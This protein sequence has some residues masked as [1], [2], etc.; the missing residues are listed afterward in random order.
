MTSSSEETKAASVV[1]T[2][3]PVGVQDGAPVTD[4][5]EEQ[6]V[7]ESFSRRETRRGSYTNGRRGYDTVP[8]K[9]VY[10]EE[11]ELPVWLAQEKEAEQ[12][13]KYD[14]YGSRPSA[15]AAS[16]Q[17]GE[18]TLEHN[19]RYARY[20]TG[21]SGSSGTETSVTG[22]NNDIRDAR[23][24][25]E[26][27]A[28]DYRSNK[29]SKYEGGSR[30]YDNN[31]RVGYGNEG[32]VAS[33]SN[34]PITLGASE[35]Q[36]FHSNIRDRDNKDINDIVRD[37]YNQRTKVSKFQ[38]SRVQSPIYKMRNFNN[39]IKYML[40]GN[41]A[42]SLPDSGK[43]K[44]MLDLCCGK[45]GDLNKC[46]F[47]GVDHYIGVDISDGS[48]K[49][50]YSR[51]S[52]N[53]AHFKL[54][55]RVPDSRKYTFEACFATGDCFSTPIPDILE[56]HFPGIIENLFPVDC[57]S[58]QFSLHYSF[59]T[60]EK[61]RTLITNVSKSLRPG[62]V[63]VGTIPSSDFIKEKIIRKDFL[64]PKKFGNDL[65]Q[66]TFERDPP[67][68]GVFRPPFG[69]KY[70]YFLQDAVDNIPEYVVPFETLRSLCED[71]GLTLKYRKSF[72]EMFNLEI[73]KYFS[74]L[75]RHLIDGM[76]RTDGKY[77][78]EGLEKEAVN[79]YLAFAFEKLD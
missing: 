4:A 38:G 70:N 10:A 43:P 13:N 62:G 55:H 41:F 24:L 53:K 2:P 20:R 39:A 44:V 74:Q 57:V 58:V 25:R 72:I 1:A 6:D 71:A 26:A 34:L 37:H 79:F 16:T 56:P 9:S 19:D 30:G 60:E 29:R 51:Y 5:R 21:G 76:R 78:V 73:P 77:G 49:E 40:L 3:S 54:A 15:P 36:T 32:N 64:S 46:E 69:N 66:V 14:K 59:E 17:R 67:E 18:R 48:V 63:F 42:R 33:Y 50:A 28:N 35:Y 12:R 7:S 8:S 68:D 11:K 31:S 65:Y 27:T 47:I 75:N 61:A 52:K 45:G 22:I 23:R